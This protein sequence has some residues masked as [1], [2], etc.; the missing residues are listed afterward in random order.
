M[1]GV[2]EPIAAVLLK[3][4]AKDVQERY[5]SAA[6]LLADWRSCSTAGPRTAS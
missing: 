2:P 5:R 3:L 4:L 6:G 1:P